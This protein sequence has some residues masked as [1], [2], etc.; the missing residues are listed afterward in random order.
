MALN[1]VGARMATSA[2]LRTKAITQ[3]VFLAE[4]WSSLIPSADFERAPEKSGGA[5]FSKTV[6]PGLSP[7]F[8]ASPDASMTCLDLFREGMDA[9]LE[10]LAAPAAAARVGAGLGDGGAGLAADGGV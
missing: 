9:A 2:L 1:A 3:L 8:R 5:F 4:V 6:I 7:N 10:L